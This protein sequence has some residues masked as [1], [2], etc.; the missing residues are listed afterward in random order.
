MF[1]TMSGCQA[2][3]SSQATRTLHTEG[4]CGPSTK[5]SRTPTSRMWVAPARV[6]PQPQCA[7]CPDARICPTSA[8]T[9]A[10][11][12][13]ALESSRLGRAGMS[14]PLQNAHSGARRVQGGRPG[15]AWPSSV[16]LTAPGGDPTR[17]ASPHE[18]RTPRPP[19][20]TLAR[21]GSLGSA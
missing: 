14:R 17:R 16:H 11:V 15:T 10:A 9:A 12:A 3:T 13:R 21:T 19:L 5:G 6:R 18:K 7:H 1:S 8:P 20:W 2:E 4:L